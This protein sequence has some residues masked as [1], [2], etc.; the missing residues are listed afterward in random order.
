MYKDAVKRKAAYRRY[1]QRHKARQKEWSARRVRD[2]RQRVDEYKSGKQCS[3]CG[4]TDWRAFQFHHRDSE[5]K[6]LEIA[7]AVAW[8]WSWERI[9]AE[10]S[11]CDLICANCHQ[12]EHSRH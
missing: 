4:F 12:I 8:G 11:K 7:Q 10:I 6:V 1:Y 2:L 9:L 5:D 3:R